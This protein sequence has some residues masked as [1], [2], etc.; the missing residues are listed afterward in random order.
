M[1]QHEDNNEFYL[2]NNNTHHEQGYDYYNRQLNRSSFSSLSSHHSYL[3]PSYQAS[4]EEENKS[5]L[6][7]SYKQD[8]SYKPVNPYTKS[9][10][11]TETKPESKSV[12]STTPSSWF[13]P[14]TPTAVLFQH[15]DKE[16]VTSK[17]R[18]SSLSID[19]TSTKKQAILSP[20]SPAMKATKRKVQTTEN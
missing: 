10:P 18:K 20:T 1:L 4:Q 16:E 9:S 13:S 7:H 5:Y 3:Y 15:K 6:D 14:E 17:K 8:H 12:G 11:Y 19:P 2:L